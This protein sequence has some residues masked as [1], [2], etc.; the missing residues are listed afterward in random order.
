MNSTHDDGCLRIDVSEFW[1][2]PLFPDYSA[3]DRQT[4]DQLTGDVA[5]DGVFPSGS[6]IR[7]VVHHLGDK[8]RQILPHH[9]DSVFIR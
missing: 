3:D 6:N 9:V 4:L 2:V 8:S 7:A 1:K 5:N